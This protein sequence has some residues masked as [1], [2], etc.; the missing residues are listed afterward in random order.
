PV[1]DTIKTHLDGTSYNFAENYGVFDFC[2]GAK[3]KGGNKLHSRV[4]KTDIP[5]FT[6]QEKI[7]VVKANGWNEYYGGSWLRDGASD[8]AATSLDY[9]FR[10][11]LKDADFFID[12]PLSKVT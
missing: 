8:R 6:E 11:C 2:H 9:A 3:M 5:S 4:K 12:E 1:S 7:E 10:S